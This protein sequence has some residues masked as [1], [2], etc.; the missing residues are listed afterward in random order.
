MIK[1]PTSSAEQ[2]RYCTCILEFTWYGTLREA[3]AET[4]GTYRTVCTGAYPPALH[5]LQGERQRTADGRA[6]TRICVLD[7]VCA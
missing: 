2:V 5:V 1:R 7:L 6:L 3:T 4:F